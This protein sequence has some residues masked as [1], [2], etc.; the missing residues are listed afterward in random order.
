MSLLSRASSPIPGRVGKI[1]KELADLNSRIRALERKVGRRG[2]LADLR[3]K[4]MTMP[5]GPGKLARPV[6]APREPAEPVAPEHPAL[7]AD[8]GMTG[9]AGA[10]DKT[11]K[12]AGKLPG[13]RINPRPAGRGAGIYSSGLRGAKEPLRHERRVQRARAIVLLIL[14]AIVLMMLARMLL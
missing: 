13:D 12:F 10:R 3:Q 14:L 4:A 5:G 1:D 8:H 11:P 9:S 6:Q 2:D 7:P